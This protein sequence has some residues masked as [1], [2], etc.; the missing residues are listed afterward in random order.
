MSHAQN[1]PLAV[2]RGLTGSL[3]KMTG[4]LVRLNK[5]GRT[6]R[7]LI[8][9]TFASIALDVI[10]TVLLVFVY[11]TAH[12]ASEVATAEHSNLIASCEAGNQTRAEQ[13][14]LWDHLAQ[15]S[16]PP[17]RATKA[18]RARDARE[19]ASLLRY[20]R[21]VFQSRPCQKVYA[22]SSPGR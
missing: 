22:T 3:E 12:S 11:G 21:H 10:L 18:Q 4:E 8:L 15:I 7:H 20:I 2:A 9:V 19:I 13:V 1:D 6:N 17:P 14:Q 5:Y 16:T